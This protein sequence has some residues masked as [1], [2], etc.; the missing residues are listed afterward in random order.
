MNIIKQLADGSTATTAATRIAHRTPELTM[1]NTQFSTFLESLK[2]RGLLATC[3]PHTISTLNGGP[4]YVWSS[5]DGA[6]MTVI[7]SA[8]PYL[9]K[10][11]ERITMELL[12][13]PNQVREA[14]T[15]L[16]LLGITK[17]SSSAFI[18]EDASIQYH[19]TPNPKL[20]NVDVEPFQL[21]PEVRDALDKAAQEFIDFM[22]LPGVID[23]TDVTITGSSANYNW[24]E[25]SDIDLHVLVDLTGVAPEYDEL[26]AEYLKAKKTAWNETHDIKIHGIP[27]EFY[28]Q[29]ID[30]LH[31]S[32]GVYSLLE[33]EWVDF[34]THNPPSIDDAAVNSKVK[35]LTDQI[36]VACKSNKAGFVEQL[37][38]KVTKM[39]KTA[40][41][42]GG[43]FSTGNLAFKQLRK[44]GL[45]D[46]LY[47]CKVNTFD[48]ELSIED[49]EWST[50]LH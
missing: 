22:K 21:K 33:D 16:E 37:Y 18:T 20:W 19:T 44:L 46:K 50:L 40:L 12:G 25:S 36:E 38:D 42:K 31:H 10:R 45:I 9:N 28:M 8:H 3:T 49:E 15:V 5:T 39:R 6:N 4:R 26:V 23:I 35:D 29:D 2:I 11:N 41:E 43:E 32:T 7:T 47:N 27:V 14:Q 34:P 24:T 17:G 1:T 13:T 30:E 48:R